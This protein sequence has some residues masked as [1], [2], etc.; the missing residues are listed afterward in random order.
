MNNDAHQHIA[1]ITRA[2]A[3]QQCGVWAPH[4]PYTYGLPLPNT[5]VAPLPDIGLQLVQAHD[6]AVSEAPGQQIGA[7]Q[8]HA[9]LNTLR[10]GY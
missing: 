9:F 8:P 1:A 10:P 5:P 6:G 4:V 3:Q 2:R 7:A